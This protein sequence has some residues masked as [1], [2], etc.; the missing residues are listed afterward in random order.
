[1]KKNSRI[2]VVPGVQP[3]P[4]DGAVGFRFYEADGFFGT[5][6]LYELDLLDWDHHPGFT[7]NI[8]EIEWLY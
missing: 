3:T 2:K 1:M 8:V 7:T 6:E 5:M 4:P